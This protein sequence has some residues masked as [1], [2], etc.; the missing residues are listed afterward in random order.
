M[1]A[2]GALIGY[3]YAICVGV[4][5]CLVFTCRMSS[6]IEVWLLQPYCCAQ[7]LA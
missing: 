2:T 7:R 4:H 1:L 6:M 3:S 5:G